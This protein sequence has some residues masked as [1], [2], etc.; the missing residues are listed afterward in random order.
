MLTLDG[1]ERY[2]LAKQVLET[3]LNLVTSNQ[4]PP[5]DAISILGQP[6]KEVNLRIGLEKA[7]RKMAHLSLG[8]EKIQLVDEANRVRPITWM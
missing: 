7:L 8:D 1:I 6:L 5:T 4:L 3:A 2:R